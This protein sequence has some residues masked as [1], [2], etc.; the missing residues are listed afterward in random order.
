VSAPR[1][2]RVGILVLLVGLVV[3]AC[4]GGPT[5]EVDA[6][7]DNYIEVNTLLN[8]MPEETDPA[9]WV[10]GVT[11]GLEGLKADAPTEISNAVDGMADALLEPVADLDEE[12]F[13]AATESE[14]FIE[15]SAVVDQF[16]GDECG[17]NA[18]EVTAVDYG[19]DAD[20]DGVAAGTTAFDF[21]NTGTELHEMALV[22]INDDVTET[23]AELL[24][25][26]EEEA[27]TKMSFVG[28]AFA[29]PGEAS[30]MYAELDP[31]RYVAIC[32]IPTGATSFENIETAEG[33]PHFTQGMVEEFT[34]EG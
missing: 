30:T 23:V 14:S 25:L 29:P 24:E 16:I 20:L 6:F 17:F 7:C 2:H 9:P 5:A 15:D 31:G 27:E 10:E 19:Y 13:F 4:N 33:P 21:T 12:G 32:F 34:V 8:N 18:V 3:A 1:T 28:V 26:P 22:R 11:A